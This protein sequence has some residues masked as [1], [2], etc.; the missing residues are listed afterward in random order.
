MKGEVSKLNY[1]LETDGR[2]VEP[3]VSCGKPAED[4]FMLVRDLLGRGQ[5]EEQNEFDPEPCG[6]KQ[7]RCRHT[8]V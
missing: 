2:L 8:E 3:R 6:L 4:T 5:I 1:T 7:W